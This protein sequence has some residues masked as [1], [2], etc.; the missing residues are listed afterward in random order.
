MMATGMMFDFPTRKDK[1]VARYGSLSFCTVAT[2]TKAVA[3][4][5]TSY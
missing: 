3:G 1:E 4:S 5:D 2:V